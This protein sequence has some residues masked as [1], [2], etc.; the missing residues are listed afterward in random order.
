MAD[1]TVHTIQY[2]EFNKGIVDMLGTVDIAINKEVYISADD[3]VLMIPGTTSTAVCAKRLGWTTRPYVHG[4]D[5]V[6]PVQSKYN[7]RCKR[8][9]ATGATV[10]AGDHVKNDLTLPNTIRPWV[11]GTDYEDLKIGICLVGA[12]PA[13]EAEIAEE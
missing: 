8:V 6:V 7:R 13:A 10:A 3:T 12:V 11:R 5:N 2:E 9:V 1:A 4:S